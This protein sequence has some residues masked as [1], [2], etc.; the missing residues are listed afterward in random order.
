MAEKTA[1]RRRGGGAV[2]KNAFFLK[3]GRPRVK[4][5]NTWISR[6]RPLANR[7]AIN[8]MTQDT[9]CMQPIPLRR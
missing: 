4:E 8:L 1:G 5:N 6:D 7:G 3:P 9:L 2:K